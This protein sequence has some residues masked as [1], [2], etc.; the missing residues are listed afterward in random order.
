MSADFYAKSSKKYPVS[1]KSVYSSD[2]SD[3][4]D[5]FSSAYSEFAAEFEEPRNR[6]QAKKDSTVRKKRHNLDIFY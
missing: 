1:K 6:R 2:P 5:D 4:D 3:S